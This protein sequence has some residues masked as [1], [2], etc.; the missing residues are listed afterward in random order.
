MRRPAIPALVLAAATALLGACTG[1]STPTGDVRTTLRSA[2]AA[3]RAETSARVRTTSSVL[4]AETAIVVASA[5]TQLLDGTRVRASIV[6]PDGMVGSAR[7]FDVR[8]VVIGSTT[9]YT[10][11]GPS[12]VNGVWGTS[13]TSSA[14]SGSELDL[15][16]LWRMPDWLTSVDHLQDPADLGVETLEGSAAHRYSGR[17]AT[18]DD[19]MGASLGQFVGGVASAGVDT[20]P[21]DVWVDGQGRIVRLRQSWDL[22]SGGGSPAHEVVTVDLDQFGADATTAP[23]KGEVRAIPPGQLRVLASRR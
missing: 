11:V 8:L 23:P 13:P 4:V 18:S 7:T 20:V 16:A 21:F 6:L 19:A 1:P 12:L 14:R 10:F 22:P 9:W 3:T 5:G 15:P 2:V 17:L